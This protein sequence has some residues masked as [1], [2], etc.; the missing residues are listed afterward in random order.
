MTAKRL[1]GCVAA[2]ALLAGGLWPLHVLGLREIRSGRWV[3]A[4][5]VAPGDAFALGYTHSVKLKPVWDHYT[6]DAHYRILQ[7]KVVFPGS[8]YGLPS[9]TAPGEVHRLLPD[10]YESIDDMQRPIPQL[11]LR[12]ERAYR[13]T[14]VFNEAPP[15]DLSN[16]IGD[17]VLDMRIHESNP[18]QL[19]LRILSAN[20]DHE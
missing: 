15:L 14:F 20:G 4:R 8:G 12:V 16:A 13:N 3:V 11:A 2:L 17:G 7:T 10:G 18:I 19:L 1:V 6:V 5:V 9:E